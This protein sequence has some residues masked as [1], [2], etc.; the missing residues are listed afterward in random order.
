MFSDKLNT[1]FFKF[2]FFLTLFVLGN[3]SVFAQVVIKGQVKDRSTDKPLPF[4]SVMI[5]GTTDGTNTNVDGEYELRSDKPVKQLQVSYVGFKT[6]TV[7]VKPDQTTVNIIL[8]P[9]KRTLS[10]LIVKPKKTK[11]RNKDNPAV[12]LIRLVLDNKEKNTAK[13]YD[14]IE[15]D[16]YEKIEL[17][18][19]NTPEKMKKARLLRPF[20]FVINNIDT[21]TFEGKAV[22]PLYLQESI[23]KRYIRTNPTKEK[24]VITAQQ[25]VDFGSFFDNDGL[26]TYMERIY[27][28]VDI[29]DN[30]IFILTSQFLSPIS[31]L[32]PTFYE[33]YIV[34]TTVVDGEKLVALSF[35]PRNKVDVLF[36]GR[37]YVTLDGKY[38]VAK[39]SMT[40]NKNINLNWV[41]DLDI[42][43]DYT[44]GSDGRYYLSKSDIKSELGGYSKKGKGGLLGQRVLSLKNYTFNQP[45]HDTMFD[46]EKVVIREDAKDKDYSYWQ[47]NRHDTLT[48]SEA[49]TYGVIDSLT[50]S[51]LF[52][53]AA[54]IFTMVV[55]GY[56][57]ITP[58]VE[59][60]PVNTFYSYNPVEGFRLRFGGRTT[61][62]FSMRYMLEGYGAYGFKD[63]RWKYYMGGSM[64]LTKRSIWQFP[65]RAIRANYQQDVKIPGQELQF[66]QEDNVLLSFKRGVNDKFL[67]NNIF[68]FDYLHEF[69][70]HFSFKPSFK[71]WKQ[72]AAGGLSYDIAGA[73]MGMGNVHDITTA[74]IGLELRYAP[75]EEFYQG[76]KFRV[77]M[78]NRYP[79][80]TLRTVRGIK[81]LMNGQYNYQSVSANIFKRA[82]MSQLG[83]SDIVLEGG[84]IFGKVPFPL[85][86]IHRANQTYSLQLESYNL[87]NF[88]EFVSDHYASVVI[89]HS[90][91]GFFFNKVPLFKR[92][93][94]R[95]CVNLKVLYG[96]VRDENMPQNS[97][98]LFKFPT[99]ADGSP[100]THTLERQPYVEGSIGIGNILNF[101]RIDLV[102]RFTYLD[103]PNIANIG[104][105]GRFKLD[106]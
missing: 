50:N 91:M 73:P 10:E 28:N 47:Q 67:Y 88:L 45:V 75:N 48:A 3:I 99:F 97:P 38:A 41:R 20:K 72:E 95:E 58:Y 68:N 106:F 66:I 83:Y 2:F 94:F 34:D 1:G 40:V 31:Q 5:V 6:A 70:N 14:Y 24:T 105:R 86:T 80:F 78:P 18:L 13:T 26:T 92:L 79:I 23:A 63:H 36:Q 98:D 17:A 82:Y 15:F 77:P 35:Y 25:K 37:M 53:R 57:R 21:T 43:L 81:G 32:A 22:L 76:K 33:F 59:S 102:K 54:D 52:K 46:G 103:N 42:N 74:E 44:K 56:K 65:V 8:E 19:Q 49:R 85:M 55:A 93:R 87:M 4:V 89:D 96:G 100:V 27:T 16:Q 60:G 84:Y 51:K 9:E 39:V 29:Y 90:F 62:D 7:T 104:I 101:F 11:Y 30:N 71:H 64:S 61:T 12:E 69:K